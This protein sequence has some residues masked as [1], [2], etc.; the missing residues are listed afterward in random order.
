MLV[1]VSASS[2]ESSGTAATR[3]VGADESHQVLAP[4][5]ALAGHPGAA[6]HAADGDVGILAYAA[7]A[8]P[9]RCGRARCRGACG[10]LDETRSQGKA[11]GLNVLDVNRCAYA[12]YRRLGFI[13]VRRLIEGPAVRIRMITAP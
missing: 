5:D 13:E 12:L 10:V 6:G 4:V 9:S 7:R 3:A 2:G 1:S 8:A 11:V